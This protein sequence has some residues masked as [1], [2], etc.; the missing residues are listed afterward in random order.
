VAFSPDGKTVATIS[1]DK[2]ARLWSATTGE[3]LGPP[4]QH[5]DRLSAAVFSPD[6]K[7]IATASWDKTARLWSA[8]TG[9]PLGPPLQHQ[10]SVWAV[11]FS[12]DGKTVATASYDRTARLWSAATGQPLGPPL[13]HQAKVEAV[14]FSPDGKTLA[15]SGRKIAI[16]GDNDR[17]ARLWEVPIAADADRRRLELW[18]QVATGTEL[19]RQGA[20]GFL[21]RHAW[22][23]RRRQLDQM[24][25]PPAFG[26]TDAAS[27]QRRDAWAKA[28]DRLW[29]EGQVADSIKSRQWF[30][31]LFH[32]EPLLKAEPEPARLLFWRGE[33]KAGMGKWEAGMSDIKQAL[34]IDPKV[35]DDQVEDSVARRQGQ[36]SAALF[37]LKLLLEAEPKR[38]QFLLWRGEAHAGMRH[39]KEAV[40]DFASAFAGDPKLAAD[41][42]NRY[43]GARYSVLA[44]G[45]PETTAS[46]GTR[47]RKQALDWL[48]A[49]VA[50]LTKQLES[51]R[52]ADRRSTRQLLR[53]WQQ[54]N[55]LAGIRDAAALAKLP[56]EERTAC[57]RLW[58]D[59]AALLKRAEEKPK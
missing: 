8:A 58:A 11:A 16:S 49:D 51:G 59:V 19:D 53:L 26:R 22:E 41:D 12:P 25:G 44:A 18:V 15:T 43:Y 20:I 13:Q 47:L 36:W 17:A 40:A 52:S 54:D 9:Q 28:T 10:D 33:V 14:A 35:A 4:L 50:Q 2:T 31:A 46:E 3:P 34:A 7:T 42:W 27:I 29:H 55:D 39:W 38:A 56:A 32:L 23:E 24:G 57:E 1:N 6:S 37:D 30:A 48:R 45:V 5:Q 21:D